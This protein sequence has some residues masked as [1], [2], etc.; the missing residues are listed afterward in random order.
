MVGQHWLVGIV[1]RLG[2]EP[3]QKC[4]PSPDGHGHVPLRV[5]LYIV[6]AMTAV[7]LGA[8]CGAST[9][10]SSEQNNTP[11]LSEDLSEFQTQILV[12]GEVT[13]AEAESAYLGLIACLNHAGFVA[14][15]LETDEQGGFSFITRDPPLSQALVFNKTMSMCEEEYT[16][17]V[18]VAWADATATNPEDEAAFYTEVAS[19]LRRAGLAVA[20][21][22]R[23]ELARAFE[24]DPISYDECLDEVVVATGG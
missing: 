6:V 16:S 24:A 3:V 12:D 23:E 13:F 20:D 21:A 8:S 4:S 1:Q 5:A 18:E 10:S 19:C 7:L 15:D 14:S 11:Y 17:V 9:V 22:S 2:C